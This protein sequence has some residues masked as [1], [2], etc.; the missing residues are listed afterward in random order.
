MRGVGRGKGLAGMRSGERGGRGYIF[1]FLVTLEDNVYTIV[2]T[3]PKRS[4]KALPIIEIKISSIY[5]ELGE[6]S[7][8]KLFWTHRL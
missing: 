1:T 5:G 8:L 7:C 4:S 2:T 3:D 6:L